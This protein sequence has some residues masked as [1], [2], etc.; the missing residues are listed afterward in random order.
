MKNVVYDIQ[1]YRFHC[2]LQ[3]LFETCFGMENI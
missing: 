1:K 2:G 3:L